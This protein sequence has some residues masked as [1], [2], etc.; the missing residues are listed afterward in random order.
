MDERIPIKTSLVRLRYVISQKGEEQEMEYLANIVNGKKHLLKSYGGYNVTVST[1][2]LKP[3][4]VYFNTHPLR[5]KKNI[6]Y[7]N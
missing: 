4:I 7:Y 1:T 2:K 3:M 5:T 6:V